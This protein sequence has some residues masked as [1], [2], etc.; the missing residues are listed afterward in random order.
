MTGD[1]GLGDAGGAIAVVDAPIEAGEDGGVDASNPSVVAAGVVFWA[2]VLGAVRGDAA[3]DFDVGFDWEGGKGERDAGAEETAV[4][5]AGQ[6]STGV[7]GKR[8]RTEMG[9]AVVEAEG[10]GKRPGFLIDFG[11]FASSGNV[12][13]EFGLGVEGRGD[14]AEQ[15]EGKDS[16]AHA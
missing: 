10:S 3:E 14:E 2:I 6:I 11:F 4:H 7:A 13:A 12:D 9:E 5:V 1:V 15:E 16:A 8:D